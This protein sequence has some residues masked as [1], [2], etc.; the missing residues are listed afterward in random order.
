MV[1][2]H[3]FILSNRLGTAVPVGRPASPVFSA[4]TVPTRH[5]VIMW[6]DRRRTDR[7]NVRRP[8]LY[9]WTEN[10]YA[11]GP[12]GL[13]VRQM[14][15]CV[16][17]SPHH[18]VGTLPSGCVSAFNVHWMYLLCFALPTGV[19]N[20]RIVF[21]SRFL[22]WVSLRARVFVCLCGRLDV[23]LRVQANEKDEDNPSICDLPVLPFRVP[24]LAN[25]SSFVDVLTGSRSKIR[26]EWLKW[27]SPPSGRQ[28]LRSQRI[29][30]S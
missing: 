11:V 14:W 23:C 1:C 24:A 10:L 20:E 4:I 27:S 16:V 6:T 3:I 26:L 25:T 7:P 30:S 8:H 21:V 12:P 9:E 2:V 13:L 5:C 22:S 17:C 19:L 15:Y 18:P 28:S 29:V